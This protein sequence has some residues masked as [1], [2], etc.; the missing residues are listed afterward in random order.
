VWEIF[1]RV[2]EM[3]IID[4]DEIRGEQIGIENIWNEFGLI[5]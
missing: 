3:T 1:T 2:S 4:I 5:G